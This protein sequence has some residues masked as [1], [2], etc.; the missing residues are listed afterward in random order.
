MDAPDTDLAGYPAYL[1][2]GY[3]IAGRKSGEAVPV[4]RNE[5]R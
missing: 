2:A 1:E 4:Y 5:E 3:R